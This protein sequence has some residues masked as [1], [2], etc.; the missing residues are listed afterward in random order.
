MRGTFRIVRGRYVALAL[1][2][3]SIIAAALLAAVGSASTKAVPVNTV[4]PAITGTAAVGQTLTNSDGT[5]TESPTF[6]YAW[7]RCPSSGGM[8]DGSD[9]ASTGVTTNTYVVTAGDV[10]FTLRA[11]VTA[12]TATDQA[13]VVT[14]ATAVV[15]AQAG[16]PNTAPPT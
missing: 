6:A 2:L 12:T 9:C 4:A 13:Q 7:L 16:P 8:A 10:G 3:G 5:W 15:V 11:R 1:L 14:N